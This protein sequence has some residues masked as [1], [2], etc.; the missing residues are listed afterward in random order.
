MHVIVIGGGVVGASTAYHL[1]RRGIATTLVDRGDTGQ[2]TA[3]GAGIVAPWTY[4]SDEGWRPLALGAARYYPRLVAELAEQGVGDTGYAPVGGI[5][6]ATDAAAAS[7]VLGWVDQVREEGDATRIGE[8]A[9]LAAGE[10]ARRCPALRGDWAGCWVEGIARV[11]GRL[12]REALLAAAGARGLRRR[13]GA[14]SLLVEQGR[15]T[16]A[17]IDGGP[18]AADAVVLA[19]GAWAEELLAPWGIA[20]GV[21]P[22][23]GQILHLRLP[24]TDV[25]A[26]PTI[27]AESGDYYLLAFPPDRVVAGSTREDGTGFDHR[28]TASGLRYLLD[29]ALE[30]APGLAEAT[31]A[32]TRVGFR[33]ST[34]DGLPVLGELAALPGAVAATGFGPVG[35]T[36]GPYAGSAIADHLA[37]AGDAIDLTPYAPR[38]AATGTG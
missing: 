26:W 28:V 34:A 17:A 27:R 9:V 19:A 22:Q 3:A 20:L 14:A 24:G 7:G 25:G 35:L 38:T 8:A 32:E 2:A 37:G 11:D 33:P 6:L 16:G 30:I 12:L 23:R 21:E 36:Y 31:V 1:L 15:C 5:S 18:V 10:P 13:T 29:T 4:A